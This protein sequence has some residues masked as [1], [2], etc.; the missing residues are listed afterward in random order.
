MNVPY[1]TISLLYNNFKVDHTEES[2]TCS[3]ASG[4]TPNFPCKIECLDQ[5]FIWANMFTKFG[6][7]KRK[8]VEDKT[9]NTRAR[10]ENNSIYCDKIYNNSTIIP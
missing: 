6:F 1:N 5:T 4:I 10:V 2:V 8:T 3:S 7:E 9:E